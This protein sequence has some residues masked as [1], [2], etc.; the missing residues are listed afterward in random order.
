MEAPAY[1]VATRTDGSALLAFWARAAHGRSVSDDEP[2]VD[3]FLGHPTSKAVIAEVG[4]TIV[5]SALVGWDGWRLSVYRL[6]VDP[7]WRRQ[8]VARRLVDEVL[9]EAAAVG[10]ARVDAMVAT[11]NEEGARFWAAEGFVPNPR[12]VRYERRIVQP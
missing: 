11:G 2:A 10:A 3:R 1:R 9:H 12:Y 6:A 5:G 8:G 4:D 7:A